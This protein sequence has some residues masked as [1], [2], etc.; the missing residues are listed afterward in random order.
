M[1]HTTGS[2][3]TLC[4]TFASWRLGV[5]RSVRE[6]ICSPSLSRLR[7]TL[8]IS[9][10][11]LALAGSALAVDEVTLRRDG[12]EFEV[13]GRVLVDAQN[14]GLLLLL[15][16]DGVLWQVLPSERVHRTGDDTPFKPFAR[17]EMSKRILANCPK[18]L[19]F[20]PP[21]TT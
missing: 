20:T 21:S 15:A 8:A 9:L 11:G 4:F 3:K 6:W 12:K 17:D 13:A 16:R 19:T 10:L 18:G 2:Q 7:G 14:S 1:N 5:K